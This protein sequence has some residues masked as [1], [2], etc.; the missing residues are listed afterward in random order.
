MKMPSTTA[1]TAAGSGVVLSLWFIFLWPQYWNLPLRTK[2]KKNGHHN[3]NK[4]QHGIRT[5]KSCDQRRRV[6]TN[7]RLRYPRQMR[8]NPIENKHQHSYEQARNRINANDSKPKP[9]TQQLVTPI[10]AKPRYRFNFVC[11]AH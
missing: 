1:V 6:R 5:I 2:N 7:V 8:N 4:S 11:V 10:T 3:S 9:R